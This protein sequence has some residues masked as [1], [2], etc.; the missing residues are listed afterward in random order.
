MQGVELSSKFRSIRLLLARESGHPEGDEEQG[1][2]LLLP[3]DENGHIDAAEWKKHQSSCRVRRFDE[4]GTVKIGR[5]RRRPGGQW[6]FDYEEGDADDEIGFKLASERFITGEYV[7]ITQ[8]GETHTYRI[9]RVE[10][11]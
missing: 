4:S 1:Y 8:G 10:K 3:L 5:L 6:Y 9:A 7:S 11:P 2:D